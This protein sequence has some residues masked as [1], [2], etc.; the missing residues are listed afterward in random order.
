MRKVAVFASGSGSNAENLFHF[1]SKSGSACI[2]AIISNH[3]DAGVMARAER[4]GIPAYSFTRREMLDGTKPI[5][6]LQD[7]GVELIVLA[8]Y[9]CFVTTPYLQAF[10]DRIVNIH[11]ALLPKYGGQGMYGHHVHEAV[12][13]AREQ[14]SGITIHLVDEQYDHGKI[15]RQATCA[16]LPDDT[17][18]T[19]AERIH[20]LEYAHYPETVEE[21]LRQL[22]PRK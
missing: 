7:L 16:V 14:E 20:A 18:D 3:A 4:L 12:I 17:P 19:L 8:G 15:L 13:A 1:F 9:M 2:S 5:G 11:P 21:Y 6:L 22:P 10:P